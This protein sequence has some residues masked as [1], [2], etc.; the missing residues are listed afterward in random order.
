ACVPRRRLASLCRARQARG[1]SAP[2]QQLIPVHAWRTPERE[3]RGRK[4]GNAACLP[5]P[6][7]RKQADCCSVL[8]KLGCANMSRP[9]AVSITAGMRDAFA[10]LASDGKQPGQHV[11]LDIASVHTGAMHADVDGGQDLALASRN[12]HCHGY[13]ADFKFFVY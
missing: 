11:A 9:C 5:F 4:E 2:Q 1:G 13:Q 6:G 10:D 7:F 3:T 12:G 8:M